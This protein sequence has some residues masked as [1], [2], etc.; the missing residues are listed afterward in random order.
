M[1]TTLTNLLFIIM[2]NIAWL[3]RTGIDERP[4]TETVERERVLDDQI[5]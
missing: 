1:P 4:W 2:C 3:C 5:N